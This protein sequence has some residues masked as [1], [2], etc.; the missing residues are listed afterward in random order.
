MVYAFTILSVVR[1]YHK[2]GVL[3]LM[4]Q[5]FLVKEKWVTQEPDTLAVA[6]VDKW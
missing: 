1:G 2:F 4:E 6:V 3:P 5:N